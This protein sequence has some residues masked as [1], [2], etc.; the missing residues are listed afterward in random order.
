MDLQPSSKNGAFAENMG[1]DYIVNFDFGSAKGIESLLSIATST[2][3]TPCDTNSCL[4]PLL[5]GPFLL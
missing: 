5:I 4:I 2:S 1:V 3:L